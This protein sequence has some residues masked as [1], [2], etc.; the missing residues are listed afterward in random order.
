MLD[1]F[2][3]ISDM[4]K[5]Y[6]RYKI[7]RPR[8]FFCVYA[9]TLECNYNCR[10]CPIAFDTGSEAS[11]GAQNV[12]Q[13][14]ELTTEQARYAVDWLRKIGTVGISFTGGEPLLK[15]NLEEIAAYA[16]QKGF[17]N[18]LNTNASLV[19]EERARAL[20]RCFDSV[21][22]SLWGSRETDN[23][24][25]GD[26]AYEKTTSGIGMLKKE[27]K[28]KININFVVN[29]DNYREIDFILDYALTNGDSVT[30]LPLNYVPDSVLDVDTAGQ[31]QEKLVA[32]KKRY[33]AFVSNSLNNI[34][35]F[36][37]FLTGG[38]PHFDCDPFDVYFGLGPDGGISGCCSY[39][40]FVGN[41][42]TLSPDAYHTLKAAHKQT[43]LDRC[44]G[45]SSPL[46][47]E[48]SALYRRPIAGNMLM[49]NKYLDLLWHK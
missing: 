20:G 22:I 3:M 1:K 47:R 5:N 19:T 2:K 16:R 9:T 27:T 24:L 38:M 39:Y 33:G 26:R 41:V 13:R 35:L 44:G 21:T 29:R 23:A 8:P 4:G 34:K 17:F 6:L 14:P 46:C 15:E 18:I 42:L 12:K 32:V 49:V 37:D 40:Y 31:V 45:C 36:S 43:L 28:L 11:Q 48:L 30:F 10:Y 25:R 7:G